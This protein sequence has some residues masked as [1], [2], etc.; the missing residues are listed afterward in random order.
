MYFKRNTNRTILTDDN[1]EKN[2][3]FNVKILCVTYLSKFI[4]QADSTNK[5]YKKMQ[6]L[7]IT[8]NDVETELQENREKIKILT[9]KNDA[10]NI[11][12]KSLEIKVNK[13]K[14]NNKY[15]QRYKKD[16]RKE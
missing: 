8:L 1:L 14:D 10:L 9:E 4:Q 3:V 6:K 11:K 13:Q 12:V 16:K 5:E 7:F 2:E 15:S